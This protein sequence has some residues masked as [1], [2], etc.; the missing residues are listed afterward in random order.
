VDGDTLTVP[1]GSS[2]PIRVGEPAWY[3]W[4]EQATTFAF[5][6]SAGS[7]TARKE[8]R[9]RVGWYWKAY[10][11]RA[12]QLRRAYL[13]KSEALTLDRRNSI[14]AELAQRA[15]EHQAVSSGALAPTPTRAL[16]APPDLLESA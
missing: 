7:F 2:D 11:T 14:A 5:A 15:A 1:D 12:G 3:A 13:G 4:L 10:R 6:S 16:A 8:R 9:G